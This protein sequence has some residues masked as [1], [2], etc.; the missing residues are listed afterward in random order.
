MPHASAYIGSSVAPVR[1]NFTS[2][3]FAAPG[4]QTETFRTWPLNHVGKLTTVKARYNGIP[5]ANTTITLRIGG[6]D[7]HLPAT[8]LT[9]IWVTVKQSGEEIPV[10]PGDLC[11]VVLS[12]SN[13]ADTVSVQAHGEEEV[14]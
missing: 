3:A 7:V 10:G 8:A 12:N 13:A 4:A 5:P 6:V 2:A 9:N 1:V 14:L 11:Q